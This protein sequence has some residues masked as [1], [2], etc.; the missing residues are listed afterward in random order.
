MNRIV[1][2]LFLFIVGISSLTA[3]DSELGYWVEFEFTK[4]FLKNFEISIIPDVRM[5]DDFT[6]IKYQ[7][8][9]RLA[10]TPFEFLELATAY[11]RKTHIKKKG[12][13][14]THRLVLDAKFSKEFNRFKSSFRT[15]F[16]TYNNPDDDGKTSFIRP[17]VKVVY[18]IKGNKFSPYTS[19]ELFHDITNKELR[20]GRFDV[21]VLRKMGKFHRIGVYYRLQHYYIDRP[22]IN[23]L[24]I[25]YRFKI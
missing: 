25:D 21:G 19:Y 12:D 8:D 23:I 13:E 1:V 5:S 20:K 11:R 16:T 4:T 24:G 9:G 3:Q 2:V 14:V 18:D 15:R 10:Y 6:V 7:F 17:R 22:S